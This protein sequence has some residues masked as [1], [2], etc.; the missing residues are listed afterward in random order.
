LQTRL[1]KCREQLGRTSGLSAVLGALQLAPWLVLAALFAVAVILRHLLAANT[2]VSWLLTVAER[3]MDGQRLYIDVIETNPPMAVLT[4]IPGIAIARALGWPAEM[5]TDGLVF[6]AIFAS[7]GMVACI[8]KNST[9]LRGVA[10]WPLAL[11]AF[12]ILAILPAKTF[13]QREHIAVVE[14]LPVLA[15]YAS[16]MK[17]ESPPFWA[18]LAA[19]IGAGL[20]L[21]FKPHFVIGIVCGLAALA[22]YAR[23]WR[24]LFA[25][26]NFMAGAILA[27]YILCTIAFYP[28]YLSVIVPLVRDI[29]ILVGASAVEMIKTPAVPIWAAAIFAALVLKR[30][31][32]IDST[33]VL[34][35]ATSFGFM[36]VFFL[37]RKGWPYHSYPMIAFAML[38][39]GY[40]LAMRGPR[41]RALGLFAM[42]TLAIAFVQSML[43]FNWAFDKAFDA[44]PL[45][46]SIARLGP[47]PKILA[48][49]GEPGLGHP[50]TRA[51]Q[52]TW[53]SRQQGL[54]VAAYLRNPRNGLSLDPQRKAV[55]D[56]YA[57][58]ER[59]MLIEDIK[60]TQPTVVLVDNFSDHWSGW[61]KDNPDVAGLLGDYR[62]VATINDIEVRAKA[63]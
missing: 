55:L 31:G 44:R 50:L 10:G 24:I 18:A 38:G 63:Y 7:L 9:A 58:R 1:K 61:L 37:Q 35:L 48:I 26:E 36:L 33:L 2:D 41:D 27:I 23:S 46:A 56:V 32:R 49:T 25:P 39:L 20:A 43:W 54:W 15:L 40:A 21:S 53:V 47:H 5:V 11:L 8:L 4:Y 59:A 12:A 16:R 30:H 28:A 13:G 19:G 22:I 51:L 42:A 57:A 34:L 29:Y 3:V 52:G 62:L 6:V 45:W 17:G 14:L 60:K